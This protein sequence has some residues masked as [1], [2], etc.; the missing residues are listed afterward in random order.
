MEIPDIAKQCGVDISEIQHA[1]I[2]SRHS[3]QSPALWSAAT[4]P[5]PLSRPHRGKVEDEFVVMLNDRSVPMLH[6]NKS[7]AQMLRRAAPCAR[8]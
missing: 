4:S 7:Y 5:R 8:K 3:I 1:S 6:I 2:S